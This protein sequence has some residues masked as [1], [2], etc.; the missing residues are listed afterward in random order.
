MDL[1]LVL[2]PEARNLLVSKDKRIKT[3]EDEMEEL[4]EK[5]EKIIHCVF[6]ETRT[7]KKRLK[8]ALESLEEKEKEILNLNSS[9]EEQE[10]VRRCLEESLARK[11]E[12]NEEIGKKLSSR[13]SKLKKKDFQLKHLSGKIK[14][15]RKK[16][17]D[18]G[19]TERKMEES[20]PK[21]QKFYE[22][23]GDDL[24]IEKLNKENMKKSSALERLKENCLTREASRA[25]EQEREEF[26]GKVSE[27][28]LEIEALKCQLIERESEI[29]DLKARLREELD[30]EQS[31]RTNPRSPKEEAQSSIQESREKIQR[32]N[33]ELRSECKENQTK[34][35]NLIEQ[36]FEKELEIKGLTEAFIERKSRIAKLTEEVA[37]LRESGED[38][39][40][41]GKKKAEGLMAVVG[42]KDEKLAR[43]TDQVGVQPQLR[44]HFQ[45]F[46]VANS[47]SANPTVHQ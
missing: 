22:T 20:F 25:T 13:N 26:D 31:N 43:L 45:G 27:E 3:L 15:L 14:H 6:A 47:N 38:C 32:E 5:Q 7:V 40:R 46:L 21:L 19:I 30:K 44:F 9:R 12:E 23:R 39:E 8:E 35:E 17:S 29:E 16:L 28:K 33:E 41:R 11:D 36:T 24:E 2:T 10:K 18:Y 34:I 1:S 37:S 42:R 4:H